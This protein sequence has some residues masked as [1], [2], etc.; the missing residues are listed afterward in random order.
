MAA[1]CYGNDYRLGADEAPPAVISICMGDEL[2]IILEKLRNGEHE[3]KNVVE[4]QPY[5]IANLSYVPKD[6]SDRNRTS[7]FAFTGNKFE[8]RMV[9]SS[10]SASTT[11]IILNSIV[12]D[13]LRKIADQLQEYKYIDDIRKNH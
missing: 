1:S 6:T 10:R 8:F 11:N 4:T 9:G 3:L 7:P 13:T 12:A 5:A 2:E